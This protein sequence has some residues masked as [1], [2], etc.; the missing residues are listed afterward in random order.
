MFLTNIF[1]LKSKLEISVQK[2]KINLST[3]Q[4][5]YIGKV[6]LNNIKCFPTCVFDSEMPCDKVREGERKREGERNRKR[7]K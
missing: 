5:A 1:D 3:H 4:V 7:K 6:I 2:V